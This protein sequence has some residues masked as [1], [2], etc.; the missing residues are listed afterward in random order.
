MDTQNVSAPMDSLPPPQSGDGLALLEQRLLSVRA[1]ERPVGFDPT[2]LIAII[3]EVLQMCRNPS[4]A[5][6]RRRPLNRARLAVR[7][8]DKMP[9]TT[10]VEAF[11]QANRVLDLAEKASNKDLELLIAD[12]CE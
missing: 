9:G 7:I 12:C 10:Y 11:I 5:D 6:L 3:L 1:A 8:R 2:I 4:P